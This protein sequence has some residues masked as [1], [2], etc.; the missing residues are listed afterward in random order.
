[1]ADDGLVVVKPGIDDFAGIRCVPD[2]AALADDPVDVLILALPAE[3]CVQMV[4]RLCA[5]G[6][7]AEV[8]YIVAGG[9]GDGADKSGFGER[10]SGLI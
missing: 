1:L 3:R 4:E 9:I 7:G 6:R 2:V 5:E 10:L 8:V